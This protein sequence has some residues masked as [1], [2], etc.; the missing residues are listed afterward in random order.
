[1]KNK[2]KK[3]WNFL[4][5]TQVR[6]TK[7]VNECEQMWHLEELAHEELAHSGFLDSHTYGLP[8]DAIPVNRHGFHSIPNAYG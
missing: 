8:Y 5:Q 7:T 4:D 3:L 1:M 2:L 6:F